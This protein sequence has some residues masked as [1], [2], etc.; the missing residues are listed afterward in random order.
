MSCR[1]LDRNVAGTLTSSEPEGSETMPL[2]QKPSPHT[3]GPPTVDQLWDTY[4]AGAKRRE[5]HGLKGIA[6]Q[7]EGIKPFG[8]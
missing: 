1:V 3:V 4:V 2:D 6:M 5:G 7:R 8:T